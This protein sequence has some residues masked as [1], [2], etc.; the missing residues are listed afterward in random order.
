MHHIDRK[1]RVGRK[2]QMHMTE[3]VAVLFIFL[4]LVLFGIVFYYK[5][6]Q[7]ALKEEQQHLL[8]SRAM[9]TTLKVLFLPELMCSRLDAESEDN[10]F[11]MLKLRSVNNTFSVYLTQYYFGLFSYARISVMSLYPER[12][13][14]VLYD[15][16]KPGFTQR[17]PTYFVV[18]LRDEI[19]GQGQPSYGY[20]Y[21]T[22]EVYD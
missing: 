17:E 6:Q 15:K 1:F 10:C 11:D 3:T 22:V 9:D 14:F 16:P 20:G 19:A 12:Q 7:V 13:E 21:L 2:G 4:I 8:A 5:Y 18:A